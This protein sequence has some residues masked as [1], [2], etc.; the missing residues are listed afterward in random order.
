MESTT[1]LPKWPDDDW[2]GKEWNIFSE[3]RSA[4]TEIW[5]GDGR[6]YIS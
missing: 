4:K 5:A 2:M 3:E 6:V 1:V